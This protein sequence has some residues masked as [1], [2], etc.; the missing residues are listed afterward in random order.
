MNFVQLILLCSIEV[1]GDFG[2]N[3]SKFKHCW[4]KL[5][6]LIYLPGPGIQIFLYEAFDYGSIHAAIDFL[7]EIYG[8]QK[9]VLGSFSRASPMCVPLMFPKLEMI[10][11]EIRPM[12]YKIGQKGVLGNLIKIERLMRKL[13]KNKK[14][15]FFLY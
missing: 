14:K 3:L 2:N 15:G 11:I 9:E 13:V 12:R 5:S 4:W 8:L 7:D 1:A 6:R 10:S